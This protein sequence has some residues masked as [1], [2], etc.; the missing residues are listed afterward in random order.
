MAGSFDEKYCKEHNAR[1]YCT[2]NVLTSHRTMQVSSK[3]HAGKG[4]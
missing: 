4:H 3:I 1:K 2:K